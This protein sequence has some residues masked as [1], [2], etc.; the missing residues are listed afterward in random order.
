MLRAES[1]VNDGTA[2]VLFAVALTVATGEQSFSWPGALGRFGLSYLGGPVAG[3]LVAWLAVR[4]R[5]PAADRL[6]ENGVDILTPFAAYLLAE[7]IGASGVLAVVVAG[8]AI[9]RIGPRVTAPAPGYTPAASGRSPHSCSTGPVRE[10]SSRL[11]RVAQ[12]VSSVAWRS[13][14]DQTVPTA[15]SGCPPLAW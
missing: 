3:L 14:A 13:L 12:M 6:L 15:T 10:S 9:A 2:L 1:L 11:S 7:L 8:L 5:R 4:A